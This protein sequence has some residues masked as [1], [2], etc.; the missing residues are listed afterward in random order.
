MNRKEK[1]LYVKLNELKK[2][3]FRSSF[4]LRNYMIDYINEKGFEIINRHAYDFIRKKIAPAN[5][6][7][8]GKQTPTKNHPVFIAMHA[9]ACCCRSC[10][11]KWHHIEKNKE[12]TSNEINYIVSLIMLWLIEEM[13]EYEY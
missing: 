5:P 8:D 13:K 3:K 11:Y 6:V 9:C 12:L 7:N 2:S 1:I 10:L 4:H